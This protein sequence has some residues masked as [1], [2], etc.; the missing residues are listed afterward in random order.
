VKVQAQQPL[1]GV[2]S[3]HPPAELG[4]SPQD[5]NSLMT[6]PDSRPRIQPKN[7]TQVPRLRVTA[8][9]RVVRL[10]LG[11]VVDE[12][13]DL[14]FHAVS[15]IAGQPCRDTKIGRPLGVHHRSRRFCRVARGRLRA[16]APQDRRRSPQSFVR[17]HV[18]RGCRGASAIDI[19]EELVPEIDEILS[20]A[21]GFS[22]MSSS[23]SPPTP[24]QKQRGLS[25]T[26]PS[27]S[28]NESRALLIVTP[29]RSI[30]SI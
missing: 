9:E 21:L 25:T 27:P 4:R 20:P 23:L 11:M 22:N 18:C 8:A 16:P 5:S 3:H 28:P 1:N 10:L 15:G 14:A 6:S 13:M 19:M 29:E 7:I 26:P 17:R 2:S 30:G 24:G 12:T